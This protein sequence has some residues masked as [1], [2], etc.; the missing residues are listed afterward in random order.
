MSQDR[1]L[2]ANA[3]NQYVEYKLE[4]K[5]DKAHTHT[6]A[7]ITDLDLSQI[8]IDT[9]NLATKDHTHVSADITDKVDEYVLG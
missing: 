8:E 2:T 4:D 7:D 6:V 3:A 5:A 1:L 9:S